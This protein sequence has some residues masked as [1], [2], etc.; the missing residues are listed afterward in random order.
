MA[1]PETQ[2]PQ[3]DKPQADP[4]ARG[5]A[6]FGAFNAVVNAQIGGDKQHGWGNKDSMAVIESIVAEDAALNDGDVKQ[7]T[8]SD[9]AMR[10]I[11]LVV[12]PSAFRQQL[13]SKDD[14]RLTKVE[15]KRTGSLKNL[16]AEFG[17]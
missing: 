9:E 8:L 16:S 4:K 17:S 3:G 14:G 15:A 11:A 2:K 6:L 1:K 12:N 10:I 7:F 5:K 13:E